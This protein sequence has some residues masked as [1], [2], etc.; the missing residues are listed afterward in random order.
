MTP[1]GSRHNAQEQAILSIPVVN[2]AQ[3]ISVSEFAQLID[4]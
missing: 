4:F 3:M 1:D 2:V